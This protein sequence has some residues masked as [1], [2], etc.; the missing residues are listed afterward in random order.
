MPQT[1][2]K[3]RYD[4]RPIYVTLPCVLSA[5]HLNDYHAHQDFVFA[6][7]KVETPNVRVEQ[8]LVGGRDDATAEAEGNLALLMPSRL[9][10]GDHFAILAMMTFGIDAPGAAIS[11]GVATDQGAAVAADGATRAEA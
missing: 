4:F 3:F 1:P 11:G 2:F 9:W 8:L 7:T 6:Q 5:N 10:P